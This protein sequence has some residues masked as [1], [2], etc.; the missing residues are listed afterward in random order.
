[1]AKELF[2]VD[3]KTA[4]EKYFCVIVACRTE[5]V[6]RVLYNNLKHALPDPIKIA[7][8]HPK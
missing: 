1:M 7:T 2:D 4:T 3:L 8:T 6:Q 5:D